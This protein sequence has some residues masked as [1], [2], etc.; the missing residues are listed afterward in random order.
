MAQTYSGRAQQGYAPQADVYSRSSDQGHPAASDH[1][2]SLNALGDFGIEHLQQHPAAVKLGAY[3]S[4]DDTRLFAQQAAAQSA[5]PTQEHPAY[6]YD[7]A[8]RGFADDGT[9]LRPHLGKAQW[10]G[11]IVSLALIVGLG[12]WGYNL[13]VR[14]VSGVPVIRSMSGGARSVPEN[15]GGQLAMHQGLSVNSVTADGSAGAP[16]DSLTLAPRPMELTNEDR[17]MGDTVTIVSSYQPDNAYTRTPDPTPVFVP[18]VEPSVAATDAPATLALS[19]VET[20]SAVEALSAD[21]EGD[22]RAETGAF[23]TSP[24]PKARPVRLAS[25]AAVLASPQAANTLNEASLNGVAGDILA[26]LG[27]EGEVLATEVPVGA[28]LVQFG[29]FQNEDIARA[30]WDRISTKFA[31]L[32]EG[33]TRVIEKAESGGKTFYRLRALGFTD[34]ADSNRFCAALTARN[35]A[36]VPARQR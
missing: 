7:A 22:A 19:A 15:P 23:V 21:A 13:M 3:G 1:A 2:G 6:V 10:G 30:E 31:A 27:S 33:K 11:A 4:V 36:C 25:A 17:P 16:S 8:G 9:P 5:Q 29:A 12:V 20:V 24:M 32:M 26:A 14:D 28:R 35:A 18:F 34:T